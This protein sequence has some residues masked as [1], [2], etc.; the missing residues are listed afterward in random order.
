MIIAGLII[1]SIY[2]FWYG[3]KT[4]RLIPV[5]MSAL[6][7]ALAVGTKTTACVMVPG[8]AIGFTALAVYYNKKEFYKPLLQFI[9][10][11]ILNFI[12]FS[13]YNYILNFIDF[14]NMF[15][16]KYILASHENFYGV[17]AV[18][19]NF[20]KYLF[21]FVDFAGF[22]WNQYLSVHIESLRDTLLSALNLSVYRDGFFSA[23]ANRLTLA[24]PVMGMGVLGLILYFPFWIFA[25]FKPLCS[26]N[27]RD[28]VIFGFALLLVINLLFLSYK[29]AFMSYSIRFLMS[30]CVISSPILVYSYSRRN[31]PYKFIVVLFA[32]YYLC[33]VSTHVYSRPF[34]KILGY[35]KAGYTIQQIREKARCSL[36]VFLDK[37]S[38]E[39]KIVYSKICISESCMLSDYIKKNIDKRNKII[40]FANTPE[41]LLNIKMLDFEGYNIDYGS[42]EDI[43]SFD[44]N[45]YNLAIFDGDSNIITNIKQFD[46]RKY[47]V[48][49]DSNGNLI[50]K[51]LSGN[52]CVYTR[53]HDEIVAANNNSEKVPFIGVC[54]Y[55]D[56]YLYDR[57]KFKYLT[58]YTVDLNFIKDIGIDS[59]KSK[60]IWRYRI[61][62]NQSNPMI[63]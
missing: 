50:N 23:D 12:I 33:L 13:S 40:F 22:M 25:L 47:D 62:E 52:Y 10:F 19:A 8:C 24:E 60:L 21:M 15:G 44:M 27:K 45:K 51:T 9:G 36:I 43:D 20:I 54:Y 4:K 18:P 37:L 26:R 63:K 39:D 49:V 59:E 34:A 46:K 42:V 48:F 7:Y 2:L 17:R 38:P 30:F 61:F 31:N 28:V 29:L 6:A 55:T 56:N 3:L 57:F 11:G 1:S 32:M 35:F 53:Y 41:R 58:T 14:G 5:F 16:S